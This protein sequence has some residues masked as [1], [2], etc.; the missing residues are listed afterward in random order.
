MTDKEKLVE[1]LEERRMQASEVLGSMNKGFGAWYADHLIAN[2][3]TVN[4]REIQR[5]KEENANLCI[6]INTLEEMNRDLILRIEESKQKWVRVE[7]GLPKKQ[8]FYRVCHKSGAVCDRFFYKNCPDLFV[9]VTGDPVT[10]W[11][12]IPPCPERRTR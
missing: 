2:G 4:G 12:P 6:A 9:K 8:G 7:E 10:H 3:V 1:L 11:M 5:L